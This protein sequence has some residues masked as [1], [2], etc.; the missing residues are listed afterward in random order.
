MSSSDY[1]AVI[2]QGSGTFGNESVIQTITHRNRDL[3]HY[4]I[5]EN[6]SYGVRL[7][8]MCNMLNIKCHMA[9]FPEERSIKLKD[10]EKLLVKN[11]FSHVGIIHNETTS[12]VLNNVEEIGQLVKK[13]LPN[14]IYFVDSMSAFGA[15]PVDFTK[16]QIDFLVSSS[17]KCIESVPGFAFAI[18]KKDK[19][20][21]C[22]NNSTSL[23]LDLFDQYESLEKTKQF[24]F[25]PPT[26]SILAFKQAL[27]ELESEGGPAARYKR[28]KN[29]HKIVR[30]GL[31]ELGFK[32]FVPLDEQGFIINTFFYPKS[33][34]FNFEEFYKRLRD[35]DQ[36]IYPGKMT[37]APCFR[38]G[39]IGDLH[40]DDM[41][42]LVKSIVEVCQDMGIELPL[43]N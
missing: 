2:M 43:K 23:S 5:I 28:Y 29:N 8:R 15:V 37:K 12:G 39:N 38:I 14:S 33:S 26:H 31:L 3:S 13:Y 35:K 30:D 16:A 6:G 34:K 1:T 22:K 25:T 4:L 42:K 21:K 10:V 27:I 11:V 18:C 24:R 32:E 17:N 36:V 19:L 20:L 9:S 40:A 41:H 7:N